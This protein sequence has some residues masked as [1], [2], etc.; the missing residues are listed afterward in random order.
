MR[1]YGS[2]I[3]ALA[4]QLMAVMRDAR[5][6]IEEN[7]EPKYTRAEWLKIQRQDQIDTIRGMYEA[8]QKQNTPASKEQAE[9][10]KLNTMIPW[11]EI[12]DKSMKEHQQ[13]GME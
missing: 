11:S 5:K 6:E 3:S 12:C 9:C 13:E 4:A 7:S 2:E 8:Y 10:L 1:D